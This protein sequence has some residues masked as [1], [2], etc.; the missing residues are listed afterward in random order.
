MSVV[1][2]GSVDLRGLVGSSGAVLIRNDGFDPFGYSSEIQNGLLIP[3][4]GRGAFYHMSR[5]VKLDVNVK[6]RIVIIIFSHID[7]KHQKS[8]PVQS[9]NICFYQDY[10][11]FAT[12]NVLRALR[13]GS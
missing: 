7:S 13:I 3:L 4:G 12:S 2:L 1:F 11:S 6:F 9:T 5:M 10:S 8:V